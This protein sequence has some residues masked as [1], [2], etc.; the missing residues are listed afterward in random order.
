MVAGSW[1]DILPTQTCD[2][3]EEATVRLRFVSSAAGAGTCSAR[4]RTCLPRTECARSASNVLK[5]TRCSPVPA[6]QSF[7]TRTTSGTVVAREKRTP[8]KGG[9]A[10]RMTVNRAEGDSTAHQ[11]PRQ[12]VWLTR[13][14]DLSSVCDSPSS[15]ESTP[16][17]KRPGALYESV[18]SSAQ[19][20]CSACRL[21]LAKRLR[22]DLGRTRQATAA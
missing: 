16:H 6:A 4:V 15:D 9:N 19:N 1:T 5:T 22:R 18:G 2:V 20:R 12:R 3:R 10:N 21:C 13:W 11:N 17:Q 8:P 7:G 14:R